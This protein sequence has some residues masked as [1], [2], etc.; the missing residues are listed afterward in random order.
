MLPNRR[1]IVYLQIPWASVGPEA[2]LS[3]AFHLLIL[4]MASIVAN[5]TRQLQ[6]SFHQRL[7]CLTWQDA[8]VEWAVFC[9]M[10][11]SDTTQNEFHV[12]FHKPDARL[13]NEWIISSPNGRL[14]P[15]PPRCI[16]FIREQGVQNILI[17]TAYS[18]THTDTLFNYVLQVDWQKTP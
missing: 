4:P 8:F 3:Y 14:V 13:W 16:A 18:A 2:T 10:A 6:G 9:L 15:L 5:Y 11:F 17:G 7:P 12:N 1:P